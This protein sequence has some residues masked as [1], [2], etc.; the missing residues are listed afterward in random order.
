MGEHVCSS[1]EGDNLL[2]HPLPPTNNKSHRFWSSEKTPRQPNR[3]APPQIDPAIASKSDRKPLCLPSLT[4]ATDNHYTNRSLA[5][6]TSTISFQELSPVSPLEYEQPR[7]VQ[8]RPLQ[9]SRFRSPPSPD[10]SPNLDCAFPPFA[11][12]PSRP[13]SPAT[14]PK[15]PQHSQHERPGAGPRETNFV[16]QRTVSEPMNKQNAETGS[17]NGRSAKPV[18]AFSQSCRGYG[19]SSAATTPSVESRT[20]V[21]QQ[22]IPSQ[23]I[24]SQKSRTPPARPSRP[25][26]VDGFLMS[27]RNDAASDPSIGAAQP[28]LRATT[29]PI[30]ASDAT[31][32]SVGIRGIPEPTVSR[33][34]PTISRAPV[35]VPVGIP[36]VP[37]IVG[38]EIAPLRMSSTKTSPPRNNSR[39]AFR[40]DNRLP[41][42]SYK[43]PV[44]RHLGA[45]TP[46]DS[47]SSTASSTSASDRSLRSRTSGIASPSSSVSAVSSNFQEKSYQMPGLTTERD[48]TQESTPYAW[49]PS[50][51]PYASLA[52]AAAAAA[53]EPTVPI[54][55]PRTAPS[56]ECNMDPP[57]SPCDPVIQLG[58]ARQPQRVQKAAAPA[59]PLQEASPPCPI[60]TTAQDQTPTWSSSPVDRRPATGSKHVCRGCK[61]PIVGRSV[62]AADGRLTGRYHKDCE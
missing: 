48:I 61:E 21:R 15:I 3:S 36:Q 35:S 40:P 39:N 16:Q 47:A 53:A 10:F 26:D 37:G 4:L 19:A 49:S 50:E 27:L 23:G 52:A 22:A 30:P 34:R 20:N 18:T 54:E 56:H 60:P 6:P 51:R 2:P 58:A 8:P 13:A 32:P 24:S 1:S 5:P 28:L 43:P 62:K 7:D 57:E 29:F 44:Q 59:F 9:P 25:D 41:P 12:V 17:R 11:S 46:S 14:T 38:P 33:R 42:I 55:R 45:H 31:A